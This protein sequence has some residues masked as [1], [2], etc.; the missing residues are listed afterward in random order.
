[1]CGII[2]DSRKNLVSSTDFAVA[3]IVYQG[4]DKICK[5]PN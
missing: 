1:M 5:T 2:F 4:I 3:I